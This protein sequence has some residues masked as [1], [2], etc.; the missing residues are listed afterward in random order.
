MT[1]TTTDLR[2]LFHRAVELCGT[3]LDQVQA[4]DLENSTP[5]AGWDVRALLG[6]MIGQNHGF[7]QAVGAAD[8]PLSAYA[9]LPPDG[10]GAAEAWRA[11]ADLVVA[12]FDSTPLD[13]RVRLVEISDTSTFSVAT[14][15]GFQLVDTV[16]HT[17]DVATAVGVDVRPDDELLAGALRVAERVP[18]G[19]A[20]ERPGASFA[21]ILAYDGPDDWRRTLMLLGREPIG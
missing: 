3:V 6:H 1:T 15:V 5:C 12:A 10:D 20:R 19:P 8:A 16:V 11:S 18:G 2:P 17:W 4:A 13:R 14:V 9:D 21:P 7:A